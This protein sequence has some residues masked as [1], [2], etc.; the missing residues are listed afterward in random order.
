M[1]ATTCCLRLLSQQWC[2]YAVSRVAYGVG[3]GCFAVLRQLCSIRRSVS[4]SVFQSLVVS[5]VMPRLDYGNNTCWASHVSAPSTS[6]GAQCRRQTDS[7]IFSVQAR[8][9]DAARPSLAADSR[10]HRLQTG[11]AR[12]PM[13]A[14][15]GA[16]VSFRP[17]PAPHWF[18]LPPS[19]VVVIQAASDPTYSA[20]HC[21]WSCVSGGRIP[22]FEQSA[23]WYHVS[24]NAHCFS[25]SPQNPSLVQIIFFI[26]VNYFRFCSLHREQLYFSSLVLRP[27]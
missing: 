20:V 14:W 25:E 21:R 15:S 1:N 4:D 5:L 19:P 22:P 10:T 3:R 6:V 23:I 24:S 13:P 18:Q 16:M 12:L 11:C 7:L 27:P 2:Q 26:T 9:T 8:H 17:H